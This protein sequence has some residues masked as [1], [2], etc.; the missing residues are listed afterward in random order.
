MVSSTS[1]R[2]KLD[3]LKASIAHLRAAIDAHGPLPGYI[4]SLTLLEDLLELIVSGKMSKQ[5]L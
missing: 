1:N 2:D 4:S 5:W 3:S